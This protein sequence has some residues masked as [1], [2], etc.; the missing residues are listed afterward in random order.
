MKNFWK[1]LKA[2]VVSSRVVASVAV[3]GMSVLANPMVAKA[4]QDYSDIETSVTGE[5]TAVIPIALGVLGLTIGI[6]IAVG[7]FKR[8]AR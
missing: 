8:I 3:V 2:R 4:A 1:N 6:P 7:V 5:I